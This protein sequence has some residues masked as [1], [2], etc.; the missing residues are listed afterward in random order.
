ME[1]RLCVYLVVGTREILSNNSR[2][3]MASKMGL[4]SHFTTILVQGNASTF[5]FYP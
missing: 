5:L 2:G 1:L 3:K 4:P